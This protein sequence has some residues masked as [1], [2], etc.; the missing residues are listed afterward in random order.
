M[1]ENVTHV[2][3]ANF[4]SEVIRSDRPVLIDFWAPHCAPCVTIGAIVE[5]LATEYEGRLK[6]VKIKTPT[7]ARTL[8]CAT[9]SALCRVCSS[10]ATAR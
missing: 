9:E 4:D 8:A 5:Q 10:C 3:D 6:V 2:T 7:I 1:A